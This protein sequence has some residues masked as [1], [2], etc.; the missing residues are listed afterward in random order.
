MCAVLSRP[1]VSD[2]LCFVPGFNEDVVSTSTLLGKAEGYTLSDGLYYALGSESVGYAQA[3]GTAPT[4]A[5][6]E[7]IVPTAY[8]ASYGN[9]EPAEE[10]Q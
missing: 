5:W 4:D 10:A 2:S 6:G 1:V 3:G 7:P 9:G 8:L